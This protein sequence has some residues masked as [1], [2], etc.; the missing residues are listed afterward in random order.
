MTRD[1]ITEV[2]QQLNHEEYYKRVDEDL[3][4]QHEQL[5]NQC[6]SNLINNGDLDVDTGQLLR[7]ANS[8][9]P[10]F[11]HASPNP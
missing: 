5:I 7:P 3:T 6:I 4:S 9:T 8:R 11:L 10:I 2:M 1:Y